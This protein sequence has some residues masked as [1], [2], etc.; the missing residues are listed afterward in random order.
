MGGGEQESINTMNQAL[1]N[2]QKNLTQVIL[3][4]SQNDMNDKMLSVIYLT[5]R[6]KDYLSNCCMSCADRND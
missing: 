2:N 5:C 4:I 1:L 3:M 6:H